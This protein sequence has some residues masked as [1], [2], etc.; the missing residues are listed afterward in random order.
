MSTC[1]PATPVSGLP[2]L[3]R[4][5]RQLLNAEVVPSTSVASFPVNLRHTET[6]YELHAV[7][8]GIARDAINVQLKDGLMT[9]QVKRDAIEDRDQ[10]QLESKW[11]SNAERRFRLPKDADVEA[12]TATH[13]DGV[14]VIRVPKQAEV[15][16]RSI[17]ID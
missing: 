6:G 5:L 17:A 9:I 14:L 2:P 8:P 10:W 4:F 13:N 12:I 11:D 3:D 1:S 15:A 16:P 7:V